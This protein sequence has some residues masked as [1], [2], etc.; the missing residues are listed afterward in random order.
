M[1]EDKDT[2]TKK[3][4]GKLKLILAAVVLIGAGAGGAFAA[5][6]MGYL[7][8][9]GHAAP[10]GPQ[11]VR[12]GEADP[13]MP[14]GESEGDAVEGEGG[15][16]F[17]TNYYSFEQPFTTNLRQSPALVQVS[18]AA[19]TRRDG[20]VLLWLA[21]HELAVRSALLA[22]LADTPEDDAYSQEGKARLQKRMTDA[23]NEVL[24]R[25]EGFGGVDA[26]YFREYIVQ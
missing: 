14:E 18:L 23:I 10:Q 16:E 12:K 8:P 17:R 6:Q 4:G 5:A 22:E 20:R 2:K 26:V 3:G 7:A 21:K 19:S 11:L 13:Y 25:T 15:S 9:A 1:A 24:V